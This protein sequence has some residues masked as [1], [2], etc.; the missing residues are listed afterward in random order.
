MRVHR[1]IVA[2][3][4]RVVPKTLRREW[5]A[6]WEAEL[7]Y[8]ES[9]I[10]AIDASDRW[11]RRDLIARS[12]GALWDAVWLRST[13]W[14]SMRV[15]ARH[16]RLTLAAVL[17]L[18]VAL[19]ATVIGVAAYN[20]LLYRPPGVGDPGSLR[21][22]FVRDGT[23]IYGPVSFD[24]YQDYR[25][26]VQT[27]SGIAAFP[28]A[29]S[30]FNASYDNRRVPGVA[31]EA[32]DTFFSVLA[33]APCI[34]RL[35]L[36]A[37]TATS[38][39]E[40]VVSSA[41]W[42]ALGAPPAIAGTVIRLNDRPV[43]IV[44][45]LPETF[46][47]MT[48]AWEPDLWMSLK[49]HETVF[50][51]PPALLTNRTRRWLHLVGRMKPGVVEAQAVADVTAVSTAIARDHPATDNGRVA[52][53]TRLTVTPPGDRGWMSLLLG[54]LL[55]V[56][57][58][59]LVVA[60]A[61]VTNLLLGL[62]ASRRHD[63]LV[64]AAIGASRLQLIVPLV[65]E[66]IA[67][68]LLSWGLGLGLAS[69]ALAQL[70]TFR[71]TLGP[72]VPAPS[73]DVRPDAVVLVTTLIVSVSAGVAV[74]LLPA[75][76]A[77]AEGVSGSLQR[78]LAASEPRKARL[79]HALLVIQMAVA[80]VAMVGIGISIR[81]FISLQHVATGF[82]AQHLAFAGVD[83]RRSG[84]DE[85]TG[86]P[87]YARI[88]ERLER[89]PGVEAVALAD[90]PPLLGAP[91]DF[92]VRDGDPLPL[93]G[94][95]MPIPYALVD[96]AYFATL[97]IG[98]LGGRTF[99]SRDRPDRPEAIVVNAT[100]AQRLWPGQEAIGRRLR[101][102]N[103]NRLVQV[104]GIVADGK[105]EDLSEPQL[106]FM[107]FALSQHYLH[108]VTTIARTS[109]AHP[110]ARDAL[111]RALSDL[112]PHIALGGVGLLTLDDILALLSVLPRLVMTTM[113]VV[114][115]VALALAVLG[116]YSTVFYSVTQRRTEIA[117]RIAL[118]AQPR[119]LFSLVL[120][121]TGWVALGGAGVGVIAGV[122]LLPLASSFFYGV[123]PVEAGVVAGVAVA[124]VAI[125][126]GTTYLVTRPW[127]RLGSIEV[128]RS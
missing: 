85:R 52:L 61:N 22:V 97:G 19:A 49:T 60:C 74:G 47:G 123:A 2:L 37:A 76:R 13:R 43:T 88:R 10:G 84:Y 67:L 80:T 128:M 15:F 108:D 3:A 79:R 59:T 110:P 4:S 81:S 116:L 24:E 124:C 40:V 6:E 105:Y 20:A 38:M 16:W 64:R 111:A 28:H 122:A 48:L 41:F 11:R 114:G 104:I 71:L 57:L 127:T 98:V 120:R 35:E 101:I 54:G 89:V 90:N 25:Q 55:L 18:S 125:A 92:V 17:S 94:H 1:W 30:T 51:S 33:V 53:L 14:H 62:A 126:L 7:H 96:D 65:R 56:V 29:I 8:R 69:I 95:G 68:C 118:G 32:S 82:S 112:D 31:S 63:M 109:A 46:R 36:R 99:D 86:P 12:A 42:K 121:Q 72:V 93:N 106:P 117:V 113:T 70:S 115:L 45:V 5:R 91:R 102:E 23:D 73:L 50:G 34:G 66:G 75:L 78:E 107:Y 58:L 83:M 21:E 87:Q 119:D 9:R 39:D 77:A 44:G 26:R 100:M 103:G 27:F